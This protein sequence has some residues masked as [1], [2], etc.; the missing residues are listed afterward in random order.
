LTEPNTKTTAP[1]DIN[2]EVDFEYLKEL[3]GPHSDYPVAPEKNRVP[4]DKE[5]QMYLDSTT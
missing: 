1:A 5:M 2:I 4:K 3:H